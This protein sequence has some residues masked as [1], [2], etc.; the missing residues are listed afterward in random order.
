MGTLVQAAPWEHFDWLAKRSGCVLTADFRAIEALAAGR[1]VGMVG[2]CNW[3]RSAVQAHM[4]VDTPIA[5]RE[6]LGPAFE[7]PFG[8]CGRELIVA[9]VPAG[10]LRSLRLTRRFGFVERYR[11][12]DGAA[13][14]EDFVLFEMRRT[15]CRYLR[16]KAA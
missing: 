7:Y 10:N 2:Y 8:E 5:W 14:G 12:K 15:E 3:T 13:V 9:L 4:A 11:V 1:I 16:G 6:L